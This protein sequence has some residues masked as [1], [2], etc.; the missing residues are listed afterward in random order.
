MVVKCFQGVV[1]DCRN[2]KGCGGGNKRL[3]FRPSP[4]KS[5]G[6]I[7]EEMFSICIW[8]SFLAAGWLDSI[9]VAEVE[10]T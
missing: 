7:D 1:E 8:A 4:A 5:G 6:M 3:R 2:Q 10:G 9:G